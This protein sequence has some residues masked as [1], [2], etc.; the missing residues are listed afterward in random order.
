M[1]DG[2]IDGWMDGWIDGWMDRCMLNDYLHTKLS[3][4]TLSIYLLEQHCYAITTTTA[5]TLFHLRS[6]LYLSCSSTSR[7]TA[8]T[9]M[10]PVINTMNR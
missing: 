7:S 2:W 6:C 9:A 8:R 1:M 5:A 4:N 3:S 10:A